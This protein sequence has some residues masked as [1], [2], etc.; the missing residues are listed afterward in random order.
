MNPARSNTKKFPSQSD[1]L[2]CKK[3]A[4]LLK[5]R[6]ETATQP[7]QQRRSSKFTSLFECV[8]K[9]PYLQAGIFLLRFSGGSIDPIPCGLGVQRPQDTGF[10]KFDEMNG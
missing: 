8:S 7:F 3:T 5:T 9:A 4:L 6:I 2:A 1:F 10:D